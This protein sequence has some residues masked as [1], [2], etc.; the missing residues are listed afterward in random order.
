MDISLTNLDANIFLYRGYTEA[1]YLGD[2]IILDSYKMC[3]YIFPKLFITKV[4][5]LYFNMLEVE[6][7][8][9][10]HKHFLPHS[11]SKD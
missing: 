3:I 9:E 7:R 4:T 1:K 10:T 2:P 6:I 8:K 5:F 11:K